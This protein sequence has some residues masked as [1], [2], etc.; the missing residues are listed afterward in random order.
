MQIIE[1]MNE[2]IFPKKPAIKKTLP[3]KK[4]ITKPKEKKEKE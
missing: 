3:K 4:P 2:Q 1:K